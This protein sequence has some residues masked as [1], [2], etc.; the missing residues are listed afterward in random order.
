MNTNMAILTLILTIFVYVF[1]YLYVSGK[2]NTYFNYFTIDLA[3]IIFIQLFPFLLE[4]VNGTKRSIEPQLIIYLACI[5][6]VLQ[7]AK[8]VGYLY[9]NKIKIKQIHWDKFSIKITKKTLIYILTFSIAMMLGSFLILAYRGGG[10]AYWIFNNRNAYLSG[11]AGNG[12]FYILF[13]LFL[14]I[15][16]VAVWMYY[17]YTKKGKWIFLFLIFCSYFTGSKSIMI[18]LV[19]LV[20]FLNDHYIKKINIKRLIF[21]SVF[22][23][24]VLSVILYIQSNITLLEYVSGDFYDNFLKLVKYRMDGNLDYTY[25]ELSVED[26]VWKLIPRSFYEE[27]PYIYGVTR[28]VSIFYGEATVIAGNTPS[29]TEFALPYADFGIVGVAITSAFS[30]LL[31]GYIEKNVRGTIEKNDITFITLIIYTLAVVVSPIN[32]VWL[33]KLLFVGI[34]YVSMSLIKI[35]R[36]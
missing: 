6:I 15:S 5:L 27:K 1:S 24:S 32:F 29:F 9:G 30:G 34:L 35:N 12:V 26:F 4:V 21:Y 33:Y 19:L 8:I 22:L 7:I 25:G 14:I 2:I 20:L 11:R 16:V 17:Y 36:K 28:I 31:Y 18:N 23:L 3:N 13:Q 10:I